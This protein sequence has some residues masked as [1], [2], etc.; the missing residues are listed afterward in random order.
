MIWVYRLSEFKV[1][2]SDAMDKMLYPLSYFDLS[3][4]GRIRTGDLPLNR[5]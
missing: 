4:E 2:T 5:R 3:T 1:Q